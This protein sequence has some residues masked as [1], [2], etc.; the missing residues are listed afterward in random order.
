M[1]IRHHLLHWL[2]N[3]TFQIFE[4]KNYLDLQLEN[5]RYSCLRTNHYDITW[6]TVNNDEYVVIS[7]PPFP[8]SWYI[9]WY[10]TRV[11]RVSHTWSM[12]NLH[13]RSTWV[14]S[15]FYWLYIARSFVFYVVF[16][17][18]ILLDRSFSML[19]LLAVYCS[20]VRFLCCI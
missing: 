9:I 14:H 11:T 7:M 17:G 3:S 18:C 8:H 20:I 10:L 12:N 2:T 15:G 16:V 19:Y 1:S 13:T 4:N 6:L 5:N